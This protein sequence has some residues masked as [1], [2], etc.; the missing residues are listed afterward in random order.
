MWK[1]TGKKKKKREKLNNLRTGHPLATRVFFFR[2]VVARTFE[3]NMKGRDKTKQLLHKKV[4]GNERE[5]EREREFLSM[6]NE[7][8]IKANLF[9]LSLSL[10]V[11][12]YSPVI[13][14]FYL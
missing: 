5:R 13:L 1:E 3:R 11:G 12:I 9:T 14:S 2:L 10:A 8:K 6:L 4:K 7:E